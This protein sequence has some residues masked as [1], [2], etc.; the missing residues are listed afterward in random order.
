MRFRHKAS[1][2]PHHKHQLSEEDVVDSMCAMDPIYYRRPKSLDVE[3]RSGDV[4]SALDDRNDRNWPKLPRLAR[5][6]WRSTKLF[7]NES[8]NLAEPT[9]QRRTHECN[10]S[11][12]HGSWCG[13]RGG[14]TM[15]LSS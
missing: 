7:S 5:R 6:Q 15:V 3:F 14:P 8:E 13:R 10:A 11:L 9:G 4:W 2:H 1:Q 12:F